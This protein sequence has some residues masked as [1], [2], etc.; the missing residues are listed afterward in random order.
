MPMALVPVLLGLA[1]AAP[2]A[3][4][5]TCDRAALDPRSYRLATE[6]QARIV[7]EDRY[8][9]TDAFEVGRHELAL[10]DLNESAT[11]AAEKAADLDPRNQLAAGVLA[12]QYVVQDDPER[13]RSAW[14]AV[15]R[16]GGVVAWTA[17]LYDVDA[18]TYFVMTFG[19]D[20]LR[21]YRFAQLVGTVDRGFYGIPRFPGPR[22]ERFWRAMGGCVDPAV[23]PDAVVPWSDVL[24]IK[25]GNWVLWFKLTRPVEISSDRSGKSRQLREIK[26][27]LHGRTGTVEAYDPVGEQEFAL[28]GRGPAGYQDLVRRTLVQFVDPGKRIRLPPLKPGAGW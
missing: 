3:A 11:R 17:T 28:R 26:V 1:S 20:A 13:A 6:V 7:T 15:L 18:R 4:E 8:D 19:G 22:N 14:D 21:V 12:R 27:A 10:A 9:W 5:L 16:A 2:A 24:E 23:E 25:A